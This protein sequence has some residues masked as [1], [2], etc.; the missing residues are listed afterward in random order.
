[1]KNHFKKII[2]LVA[3]TSILFGWHFLAPIVSA[4][5]SSAGSSASSASV[6]PD[7]VSGDW[8]TQAADIY[9]EYGGEGPQFESAMSALE[10][11]FKSTIGFTKDGNPVMLPPSTPLGSKQN[12]DSTNADSSMSMCYFCTIAPGGCTAEEKAGYC[13]PEPKQSASGDASK[14][15]TG[16]ED[17]STS[18]LPPSTTPNQQL[19]ELVDQNVSLEQQLAAIPRTDEQEQQY[20]D[21]I[22]KY[23]SANAL[24]AQNGD[25]SISSEMAVDKQFNTDISNLIQNISN[26]QAQVNASQEPVTQPATT[27]TPTITATPSQTQND[28]I[29]QQLQ[30]NPVAVDPGGFFGNVALYP[31]GALPDLNTGDVLVRGASSVSDGNIQD[32]YYVVNK[33]AL[34]SGYVLQGSGEINIGGTPALVEDAGNVPLYNLI[35]MATAMAADAK[36]AANGVFSYNFSQTPVANVG[37]MEVLNS[38]M[39]TV[40]G[41]DAIMSHLTANSYASGAQ[42]TLAQFTDYAKNLSPDLSETQVEKSIYDYVNNTIQTE[43]PSASSISLAHNLQQAVDSGQGVCRDKA[44]ALEY[45]LNAAD[46]PAEEVITPQHVFVAV[47]NSDGTVNH[48]LDPMY[49]ETYVSLQRSNISSGQLVQ[50]GPVAS[51]QQSPAMQNGLYDTS[52]VQ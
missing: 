9:D 23:N 6:G 16:S 36:E 18:Q 8:A 50:V 40:T 27:P 49:Y 2:G 39:T 19:Q 38:V 52:P 31:E 20:V 24:N 48:Y 37:V 33:Y 1:M 46:I 51:S 10:N 42:D 41:N 45:A 14:G 22:Q 7:N 17:D 5:T 11:Q 32:N 25:T 15:P 34:P 47:M 29:A 3:V 21:I 13:S 12:T 4:Q 43:D 44:A 28:T 35:P 26:A 30:L